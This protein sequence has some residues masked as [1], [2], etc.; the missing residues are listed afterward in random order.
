M[1]A[2]IASASSIPSSID[3][4]ARA[5]QVRLMMFDVDGVLTDGRLTL[6]EAGGMAMSF[7]VHD[8]QGLKLLA[9]AG[10]QLALITRSASP[11]IAVRARILGIEQVYSGVS[12]KRIALAELL[13]RTGFDAQCCGYM[14]DDWPDLPVMRQ[15]HFAAAPVHIG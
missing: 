4:M 7:H 1:T 15:V 6:N 12:D 14:G 2:E 10:V 3:A 5:A 9:R 8:G 11:V 13:S